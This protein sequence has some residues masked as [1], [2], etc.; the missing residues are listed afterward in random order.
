MRP[1][2]FVTATLLAALT[3]T[4]CGDGAGKPMAGTAVPTAS[5]GDAT[6]DDATT[7]N[8]TTGDGSPC[9]PLTAADAAQLT[10]AP[11]TSAVVD[12]ISCSYRTDSGAELLSVLVEKGYGSE[13]PQQVMD[14]LTVNGKYEP[15]TG[16][17]DAAVYAPG[18]EIA[19]YRLYFVVGGTGHI[20]LV[21]LSI[22]TTVPGV[23]REMTEQVAKTIAPKIS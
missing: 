19:G 20:T 13:P 17:G 23:S 15:V 9:A 7:G 22:E 16:I 14:E 4:A 11:I 2:L 5:T 1:T 8:A 21:Q 18:N 6:T 3:L 10:H 12:D